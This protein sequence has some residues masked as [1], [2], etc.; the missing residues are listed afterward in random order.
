MFLY[1][2]KLLPLFL[3][4]L[5]LACVLLVVGL[6]FLRKRPRVTAWCMGLALIFLLLSSN[7][8]VTRYF[9]RSLEWQ[10]IPVVEL[11]KAEA[12]VVLGGAT[13]SALP[14]RPGVDL[15]EAGD[16]VIYAAQLFRQNKAPKIVLSG[17]RIDWRG[18]GTAESQ[19]MADILISLGI[20][21]EAI[22]QD[23]E[24][25]NTFEN[26]VNTRK[27][28][29]KNNIKKV[30]LVTSAI[31]MPRSLLIFKQQKID[32]I[33]APT[34]FLISYG[35]LEELSSTPKSAILNLLPES[36]NLEKFTSALKEYIGIVVYRL[37]G[38]L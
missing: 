21:K 31:H 6:I 3:Y 7:G 22:L 14:P 11:P 25:F 16:R 20:P 35:E 27:I 19:D 5:G 4:P 36:S 33:P 9:V 24:S 1:L 38:W 23:P 2:S 8:W 12:I 29:E 18:K 30:I 28:L 10:N 32:V 17:G 34:D 37:K 15:S 13:R 26:A